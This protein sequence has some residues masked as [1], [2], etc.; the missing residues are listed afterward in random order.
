MAHQVCKSSVFASVALVAVTYVLLRQD[1]WNIGGST[2][3]NFVATRSGAWHHNT[4]ECSEDRLERLVSIRSRTGSNCPDRSPWWLKFAG[5]L[6]EG[7]SLTH[8]NIGCN[9]GFD[10]LATLE[11]LFGDERYSPVAYRHRLEGLG[12]M[13]S[14]TGACGQITGVASRPRPKISNIR[15]VEGHCIEIARKNYEVLKAG[16]E[17]LV[18]DG[19]VVSQ[20]AMGAFRGYVSFPDVEAGIEYEGI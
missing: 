10:L 15:K 4:T 11:D 20:M 14:G 8:V 12:L 6:S 19:V 9:K 5:E 18:D 2:S 1:D 17:S 7:R 3:T 13:F 16:M